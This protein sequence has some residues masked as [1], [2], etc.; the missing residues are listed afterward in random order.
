VDWSVRWELFLEIYIY[1]PLIEL[2][3]AA[4]DGTELAIGILMDDVDAKAG[5]TK[6]AV[7]NL[8]FYCIIIR[9]G[10]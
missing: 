7:E 1:L 8:K 4:E 10:A 5:N 9:K 6:A 3:P 2:A